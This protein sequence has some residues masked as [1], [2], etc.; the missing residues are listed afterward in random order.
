M[1]TPVEGDGVINVRGQSSSD[2]QHGHLDGAGVT[3]DTQVIAPDVRVDEHRQV[4]WVHVACKVHAV[5]LSEV[6]VALFWEL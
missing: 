4:G 3:R 6:M 1:Q 2:V 5:H